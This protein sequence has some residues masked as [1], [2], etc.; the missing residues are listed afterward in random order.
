MRFYK[1]P[2]LLR[3]FYP[4]AIWHGDRHQ[5]KIYLTFDDGP[6]PETTELIL[7]ILADLNVPATFFCVGDNIKKYPTLFRKMMAGHHGIGNHSYHHLNGWQTSSEVYCNDVKLCDTAI[8]GEGYTPDVRLF[9]PPYGKITKKELKYLLPDYKIIMWDVLSYDFSS[10]L[11]GRQCLES[12]I[13]AST[14]G[15]IIIFHDSLKSRDKIKLLVYQYIVHFLEKNFHF[16]K[17]E[18]L[19]L[20]YQ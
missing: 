19:F 9:R 1:T 3:L 7:E 15:S 20:P 18:E 14:E 5:K 12:S 17:I 6:V 4:K 16:C 8:C 10:K 2:P 11:N 13:R